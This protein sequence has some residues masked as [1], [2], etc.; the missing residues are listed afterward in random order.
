LKVNLRR[1][2]Y[3]AGLVGVAIIVITTLATAFVFTGPDS[4]AYSFLNRK[5]STLGQPEFSGWAMLFNWGLKV[6]GLLLIVFILGLSLYVGTWSMMLLTISGVL[7]AGGVVFV[8]ICPVT[9]PQCHKLAAA[10]VFYSGVTTTTLFTVIVLLVSQDKLAKWLALPSTI[11][12]LAFVTFAV[13]LY[14]QYKQPLR[15]FIKGPS[16]ER[17]YLWLPSLLE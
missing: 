6:G 12:S 14:V 13:T 4:T 9:Q 3:L 16:D 2:T 17:P 7:M 1:L 5:V 10:T 11:A 15:V 8:G